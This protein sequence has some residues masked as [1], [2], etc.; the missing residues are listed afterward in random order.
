MQKYSINKKN[1]KYFKFYSI[2]F[3]MYFKKL[4]LSYFKELFRAQSQ[5]SLNQFKSNLIDLYR[6]N[7]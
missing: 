1:N 6:V 2:Y 3:K 5:N 4:K 7:L